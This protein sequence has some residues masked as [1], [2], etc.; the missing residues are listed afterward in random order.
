MK[1]IEQQE[2]PIQ[3]PSDLHVQGINQTTVFSKY[4]IIVKNTCY[5]GAHTHKF[6]FT[7]LITKC[8]VYLN[9]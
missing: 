9:M 2:Q 3:V 7:V 1:R 6:I 4:N 8:V 5:L